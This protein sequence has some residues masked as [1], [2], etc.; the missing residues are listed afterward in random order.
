[1][2]EIDDYIQ[3]NRERFSR[4]A[5]DE[6]LRAAGHDQAAIEA[7]WARIDAGDGGGEAQAVG[8]G[9]RLAAALLIL[10]AIAGYA[11]VGF[12]GI[13]GLS[14]SSYYGPDRSSGISGPY[15]L[16]L[17]AYL[18]AMLVGLGLSIRSLWRAP[19]IRGTGAAVVAALGLSLLLL[20]GIN[21]ACFVATYAVS[22]TN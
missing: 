3:A 15:Q 6:K 2:S 16:V 5:L 17:V 14:L 9:A 22:A 19:R 10:V 12:F 20:I 18:V 21:G 8:R 4:E 7:A 13:A 11:Y 1:M